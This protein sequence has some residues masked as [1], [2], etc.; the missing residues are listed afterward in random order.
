MVIGITSTDNTSLLGITKRHLF[1]KNW[2]LR[3]KSHLEI[4]LL[5]ENLGN[6]SEVHRCHGIVFSG[7]VTDIH[8]KWYGGKEN[9]PLS[10]TD[11]N[12]KRDNFEKDLFETAKNKIPILG[13]CRGLQFINVLQNGTLVQD[14]GE[15]LNSIHRT[16]NSMIADKAHHVRILPNTLLSKIV[17]TDKGKVNSAH[18]Q[19]I[20]QLGNHL[21]ANAYDEQHEIIEG[22][23]WDD[24]TR[25]PFMLAVQWH[26]ERMIRLGEE[27]NVLSKNIRT[28]FIDAILKY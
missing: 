3:G 1:Y 26:P 13:I 7:G 19:V 8:P 2:L 21:V 16:E 10:P 18:H 12:L 5:D 4:I 27:N 15:P 25:F 11:F 22:I 9:Y 17:A 14:L 24:T 20:S 28:A 6:F 23:E